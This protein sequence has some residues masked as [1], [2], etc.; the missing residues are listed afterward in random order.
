MASESV[1]LCQRFHDE[2]SVIMI[3][4]VTDSVHSIIP[5]TIGVLI[6]ENKVQVPFRGK[7][8]LLLVKNLRGACEQKRSISRGVNNTSFIEGCIRTT[9]GVF[10]NRKV[11][12]VKRSMAR[13]GFHDSLIL[14]KQTLSDR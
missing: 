12:D 5:G 10:P 3:D 8:V 1:D 6:I 11:F 2:A 14:G 4:K 9:A 7:P 13:D